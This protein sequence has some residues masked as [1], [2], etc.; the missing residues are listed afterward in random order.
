MRL[1]YNHRGVDGKDCL[2]MLELAFG[3]ALKMKII[4]GIILESNEVDAGN[5]SGCFEFGQKIAQEI[6][7]SP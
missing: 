5:L 6:T 3:N 7:A 2:R 4:P 1:L